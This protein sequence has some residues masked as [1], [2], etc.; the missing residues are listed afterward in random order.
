MLCTAGL[1]TKHTGK[2]GAACGSHALL[3]CM[4]K[5]YNMAP[6]FKERHNGAQTSPEHAQAMR[7]V[8]LTSHVY[9]RA[10]KPGA[11]GG[12]HALLPCISEFHNLAEPGA[13]Y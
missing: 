6:A 4:S 9:L 3:L 8:M 12:S 10:G 1:F 2:P 5:L 11:D 13:P 7:A